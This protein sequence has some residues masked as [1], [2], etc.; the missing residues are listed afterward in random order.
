MTYKYFS[1]ACDL[2]AERNILVVSGALASETHYII[3]KDVMAALRK[4]GNHYNYG[5][6]PLVDEDA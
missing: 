1:N 5:M 3:N 6:G 2:A 4:G